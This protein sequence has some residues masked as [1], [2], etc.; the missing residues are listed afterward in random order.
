MA[1][2]VGWDRDGRSASVTIR[3]VGAQYDDDLNLRKLRSA[4]TVGAFVAWPVTKRVQLTG[5][6]DNLFNKTVVAGVGSDGAIE[7]A[8]PRA[9]W[10]GL[11]LF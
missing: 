4:T 1:A 9:F 10:L 6:A 8:T 5:R 11:R 2:G 7:R 3:H